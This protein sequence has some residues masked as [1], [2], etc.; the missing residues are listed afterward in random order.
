M[1]HISE[2]RDKSGKLKSFYIKVHKGK[3]LT[4]YHT[5]FKVDPSWTY[6][7]ACK[8]VEKFALLYEEECK[9]GHIT[10]DQTTLGEYMTYTIE[11]KNSRGLY[12]KRSYAYSK[13]LSKKIDAAIGHIKLKDLTVQ[14]LNS[15]YS[16]LLTRLSPK[17]VSEYHGLIRTTLTQAVKENILTQNVSLYAE[18]PK[19]TKKEVQYFQRD[20]IIKILEC[21]DKEDLKHKCLI[22]LFVYTG[23][24]RGEVAGLRWEDI[25]FDTKTIHICRSVLYSPEFGV[26]EDTPK[27]ARSDR[28]IT[29]PGSLIDLLKELKK[30]S[31][32]SKYVLSEDDSPIH[33]DSISTYLTRF[34]KKYGLPHIH[35]H[36]FRHTMASMLYHEGVDPV[37]I[38]ARLGHSKVSTTAD[39]YSHTIFGHD[40]KSVKI[41]ENCFTVEKKLKNIEK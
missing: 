1:A 6:K 25:N 20:E 21:A 29:L 32:T 10:T 16:E 18:K 39:I 11:L 35:S 8:E 24:R 22:N 15:Y 28:Y 5:T 23:A 37:S 12:K 9:S 7:R 3:G 13:S 36:A 38:S 41:L 33:P 30:V 26:F 14:D 40:E 31:L 19:L 2:Y 27:T 17:S 4:P 34:S